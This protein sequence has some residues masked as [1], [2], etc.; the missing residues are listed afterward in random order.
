VVLAQRGTVVDQQTIEMPPLSEQEHS[1]GLQVSQL[2]EAR[3]QPSGSG[4][5]RK[6]TS[7][8]S[9]QISR[10]AAQKVH[11]QR[12]LPGGGSQAFEY[13]AADTPSTAAAQRLA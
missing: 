8:V 1:V 5:Q 9:T 6:D 3:S 10:S 2:G 13:S 4:S 12:T 7:N 11:P